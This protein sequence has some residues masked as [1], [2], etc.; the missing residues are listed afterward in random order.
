MSKAINI[1]SKILVWPTK[2]TRDQAG[3]VSTVLYPARCISHT[4]DTKGK[5]NRSPTS[6]TSRKAVCSTD[7]DQSSPTGTHPT[8]S[9][10]SESLA[11]SQKTGAF[12]QAW[13][14]LTQDP[15]ILETIQGYRIPF[16]RQLPVKQMPACLLRSREQTIS[17]DRKLLEIREV[18]QNP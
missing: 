8:A 12:V 17:Q 3:P 11:T 4:I 18:H 14:Q 2:Y 1:V 7:L 9:R 5:E 6:L 13:E 15:W 16:L 10:A